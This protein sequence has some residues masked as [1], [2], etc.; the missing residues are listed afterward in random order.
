MWVS[1]IRRYVTLLLPLVVACQQPDHVVAGTANELAS[2]SVAAN[3]VAGAPSP[4]NPNYVGPGQLLTGGC[5]DSQLTVGS[6]C[7]KGALGAA[8]GVNVCVAGAMTCV[9]CVPGQVRDVACPADPAAPACPSDQHRH[10]VCADAGTWLL[11]VCNLCT[12]QV[13]SACKNQDSCKSGD[14]KV[15]P[16]DAT[17]AC[18]GAKCCGQKFVCNGS[19]AWVAAD[20]M[21]C[22]ALESACNRDQSKV[23]ACGL[24]GQTTEICDGCFFVA[25]PCLGQGSCKAG[26]SIV[27]PCTARNCAAGFTA[28]TTCNGSCQWDPPSACAGCVLGQKEI[29][30]VPCTSISPSYKCGQAGQAFLCVASTTASCDG[31]GKLPQNQWQPVAANPNMPNDPNNPDV[32]S[33]LASCGGSIGAPGCTTPCTPGHSTQNACTAAC[34]LPGT[35]TVSCNPSGCGYATSGCTV[36]DQVNHCDPGAMVILNSCA[37]C[38]GNHEKVCDRTCNWNE[39]KCTT[40]G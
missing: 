22:Q 3:L 10:D 14:I 27:T 20:T 16:C 28:T 33:C 15:L 32:S 1:T 17:G 8:A 37:P 30:Q 36:A 39:V 38:N 7:T 23:V 5:T 4:S 6:A 18:N 35:Q 29:Q 11:G 13:S 25:S 19:C 31:S 34:G 24:C 26:D 40:C 2:A 21:G 9:D 12:T